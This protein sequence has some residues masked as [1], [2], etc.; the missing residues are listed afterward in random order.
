M[1]EAADEPPRD[2]LRGLSVGPEAETQQLGT[3]APLGAEDKMSDKTT[4]PDLV[5][6]VREF[7]AADRLRSHGQAVGESALPYTDRVDALVSE[8]Y[9]RYRDALAA[10]LAWEPAPADPMKIEMVVSGHENVAQVVSALSGVGYRVGEPA[11]AAPV[12]SDAMPP[13]EKGD[14]LRVGD[15]IDPLFIVTDETI[16]QIAVTDPI[17]IEKAKAD[18]HE[19]RKADGRVWRR[20]GQ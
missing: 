2:G 6:L 13:I 7:Q 11:P 10:L 9:Q 1:R 8:N 20:G 3:D 17:E 19:I 15:R 18:I 4:P 14:W 12:T 16:A 5:A